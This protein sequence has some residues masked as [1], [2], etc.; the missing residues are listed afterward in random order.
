MAKL[1]E[2]DLV[3][4][5]LN[6]GEF[7][8]RNSFLKHPGTITVVIGEPISHTLG[9]EVELTRACETWIEAQQEKISGVGPFAK[10]D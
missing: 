9:N 6:S 3:P 1:F 2:M 5:A 7:W 8:P 4:V 10:R